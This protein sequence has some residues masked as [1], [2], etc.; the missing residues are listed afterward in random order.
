MSVYTVR[1]IIIRL[2]QRH[3]FSYRNLALHSTILHLQ[4]NKSN[5]ASA[6]CILASIQNKSLISWDLM[7]KIQAKGEVIY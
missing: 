2:G 1:S 5:G 6:L 7:I 4:S 3:I